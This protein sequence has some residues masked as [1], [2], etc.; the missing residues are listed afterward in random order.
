[1]WYKWLGI[2]IK[3]SFRRTDKVF[4]WDEL[5]K[6]L[7]P[8]EWPSKDTNSFSNLD[9]YFTAACLKYKFSGST[10]RAIFR[11]ASAAETLFDDEDHFRVSI[12][13]HSLRGRH[14]RAIQSSCLTKN[15]L[16]TVPYSLN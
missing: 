8:M 13:A 7:Q 6:Q 16:F 1:M 9:N 2:L 5:S 11:E 3:P 12:L 15:D 10:V 4:I 14:M